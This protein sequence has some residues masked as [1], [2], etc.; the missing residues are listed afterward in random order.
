MPIFQVLLP[1]SFCTIN[2]PHD[3]DDLPYS[4]LGENTAAIL[5]TLVPGTLVV[6]GIGIK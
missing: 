1:S 4:I 5:L 2:N 3:S 6:L